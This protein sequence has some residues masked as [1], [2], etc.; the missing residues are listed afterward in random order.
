M[1]VCITICHK[2]AMHY[3][4]SCSAQQVDT[5]YTPYA[6][7]DGVCMDSLAKEWPHWKSRSHDKSYIS[8]R[9]LGHLYTQMEQKMS[10]VSG[11][12]K[13]QQDRDDRLLVPPRIRDYLHSCELEQ[14]VYIQQM[15]TRVTEEIKAYLECRNQVTDDEDARYR[16]Q[17]EF[18]M[19]S[20]KRLIESENDYKRPI[21]A[22]IVYEVA[23]LMETAKKSTRYAL[24]FAYAVAYG[25]IL[26]LMGEANSLNVGR[27]KER[28]VLQ[29]TQSGR[30]RKL[31]L[32]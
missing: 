13:G 14:S 5:P 31:M 27:D 7:Q 24:E 17:S 21:V 10:E 8:K 16:I 18:C 30:K 19:S 29:N 15:R 28:Y 6:L 25:E 20:R 22:A 32:K 4:P 1:L 26:S 3:N 9:I 12:L 23:F 2:L 11:K